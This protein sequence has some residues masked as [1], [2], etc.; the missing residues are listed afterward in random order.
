MSWTELNS[1]EI[2]KRKKFYNLTDRQLEQQVR[3]HL[4]GA[5]KEERNK[6]YEDIYALKNQ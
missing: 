2:Q 5:T 3:S 4:N 6:V 1:G